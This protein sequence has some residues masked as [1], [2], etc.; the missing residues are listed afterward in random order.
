MG[1]LL[2]NIA[3]LNPWI[4]AGLAVLPALWFLLRVMP[5][6]P[7]LLVFPATRFLQGLIPEKHSP[8]H[9]P[10]WILLLR[11]LVAGLV[12]LA[13]AG[14]VYNP[15]SG[16]GEAKR[17]RLVIDN[18][19]AAAQ[20]WDTQMRAAND[21]ISQAARRGQEVYILTTAPA[22]G[23][24]APLSLGPMSAAEAR[25]Q[26]SALEPLPWVAD[27]EAAMKVI[28]EVDVPST[29]LS[30][31]L[32]EGGMNKLAEAL[33]AHGG[34]SYIAPTSETLPL[35]LRAPEGLGDKPAI[36]ID[37]PRDIPAGRPVTLQALGI[38]GQVLDTQS[39][40]LDPE[41]LPMQIEFDMPPALIKDIAQIR[42]AGQSGVGGVYALGDR[43]NK[44]RVGIAGPEDDVE[45]KPFIED[46]YYLERALSP[47]A[48]MQTGD[49]ETLL[50]A[51]PAMIIL[52]DV[53]GMPAG[54]LN[55]LEQWVRDG[56]LLL[57][58]AGPNMTEST[59]QS[60]LTPT[61][62]RSGGRVSE[63]SMSW[64][65][66]P[67]LASFAET[68]PLYGIEI[69]EDIVVRQQILPVQ[70]D[71]LEDKIWARLDD[72]TPL[73]TASALD[74]GLLVM[75][76]TGASAEWSDLALSGVYVEIL[77]RILR[78]SGRP[79]KMHFE[80]DGTLKPIWVFDGLAR[81]EKPE[82]WVKAIDGKA[83]PSSIHPPGLYGRGASEYLLNLGD[84]LGS[85]RT[86]GKLPLGATKQHYAQDY[87]FNLM[88]YLLFVAALLL[89]VDGIIMILLSQGLRRFAVILLVLTALPMPVQAADND[90]SKYA[91]GFYLA[92][93]R[94][95][96]SSVD[97][98]S[99]RGLEG[100]SK[101]L[102]YRT[103][104]EPDGVKALDPESDDL[105]F[106]PLIYWPITTAQ[107]PLSDKAVRNVQS[108]LDHGGTILFD[109]RE[110]SYAASQLGGTK[111]TQA[112]RRITQFLNIPPLEP[113]PKDHVL[114]RSFYLIDEFPGRYSAG[115][116][117]VETT[118]AAGRDGVSSVIIGS[119]DWAGLWALDRLD[120]ASRGL[121]I[122]QQEL[123]YR[124]G[125][126]LVMYA[127]T[128]NYKSDQVHL[129]HILERL[130]Q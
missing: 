94:T 31:G 35:A 81:R 79:Q 36:R 33:Q 123:S 45:A 72:G 86:P 83:A 4:L 101:V 122:R 39:V 8:S 32:D 98:T 20:T 57:R 87:E 107:K 42:M 77:Q 16:V 58:F 26:L 105:S 90:V 3:F 120:L 52:P 128:G 100:L 127:L 74:K 46:L 110:R 84:H 68:S 73:I 71:D 11:L 53:A 18:D 48:Q 66:A 13:L 69:R 76:H 63:G 102:T 103:S 56:G 2:S 99:Q 109:T 6:A 121:S 60:F 96:D 59:G 25:A 47:Y 75:I 67:K 118:S 92:Y 30:H 55:K 37:G 65:D 23:K 54:T 38:D 50:E 1:G 9:T 126:N 41:K 19:W 24:D 70:S 12:I 97:L 78:L 34:L 95:G 89:L 28:G 93:I 119:N 80:S 91:D 61:P 44:R 14:P 7:R 125:I 130:G 113:L 43:F 62:L 104:A 5:P 82:G 51:S 22:P 106:F 115:K 10:W 64:E 116:L 129:P 114:G 108:Y 15:A 27:Y 117:W 21:L 112:L 29:W 111:N 88:P 49:I 17:I 124:F 85:L 40:S